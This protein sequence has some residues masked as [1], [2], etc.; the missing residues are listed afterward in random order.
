M[1]CGQDQVRTETEKEGEAIRKSEECGDVA[2][3]KEINLHSFVKVG[4][5]YATT[6]STGE[7]DH[8]PTN[9]TPAGCAVWLVQNTL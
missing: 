1:L 5:L 2:K 8:Q 6:A 3:L 9:R 4:A 7:N